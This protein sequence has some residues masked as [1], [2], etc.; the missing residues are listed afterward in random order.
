[1]KLQQK[2]PFFGLLS[3]LFFPFIALSQYPPQAGNIGTSAIHRDS[4]I[5]KTFENYFPGSEGK[6]LL[7]GWQSIAD[8]SLG[9]ANVG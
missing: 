9:N 8:T 6:T 4:S 2:V 3:F 5:I 1:M 7:R